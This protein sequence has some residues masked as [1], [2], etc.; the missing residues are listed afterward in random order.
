[1]VKIGRAAI[2]K[3]V[4]IREALPYLSDILPMIGL[5]RMVVTTCTAPE[6][7]RKNSRSG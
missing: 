3:P 1:M 2:N 6:R 7:Y 4:E 5:E